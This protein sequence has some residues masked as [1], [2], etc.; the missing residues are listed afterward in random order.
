MTI[1]TQTS[2]NKVSR[3]RWVVFAFIA[4]GYLL[5]FMQ[6]TG[7]GVIADHLQHQF[8]VSAMVLGT[9]ASV[10]YFLYMVLQIPVGLSGDNVGPERLFVAGLLLDGLGT[11]LFSHA[12][13]FTELLIGRGVV[14]MGDALIWVNIVLILGKWFLPRE[15]G[16]LLG[17]ASTAGN[18][19]ALLTTIPFAAWVNTAGW[20]GPFT[21]LGALL[22]INSVAAYF[23]LL[24]RT[25]P[26]RK[27]DSTSMQHLHIA[28]IPVWRTLQLVVKDRVA[29]A[30]F[31]CH[32]G[33]MGTYIGFV[34]LWAIPLFMSTYGLGRAGA[35]Q[36][37]LWGFS[38]ALLGGP[39][40]GF[41]S[42]RFGQ[43]RIPYIVIQLTSFLAWFSM[44]LF[45]AHPP[46]SLAYVL[47]F[48]VGF[49]CGGSLLTFATIRDLTPPRRAGVTS[50][51]A[52]TGGFLS[53][54]LLPVLFGT[55]IDMVGK[56]Q[57]G[58]TMAL[59]VPTAFAFVGVVGSMLIPKQSARA[60]Q[61]S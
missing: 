26:W 50:G 49:G 17:M 2:L 8:A 19:G 48:V 44:V 59:W 32:F 58:F 7:P 25:W 3:R 21:T 10:Q 23:L 11:L 24:G 9:M 4:S 27:R 41:L 46:Q 1:N 20:R 40:M 22:V 57:F 39:V 37:T 28:K 45:R 51:F 15:F 54:V 14:G 12:T 61:Q 43:R 6:R 53:A 47:M 5:A 56:S 18:L 55:V 52:N 13:S 33:A 38:G 36:F 34:S 35:A 29:W 60:P 31:A 42:D 16:A 30:T